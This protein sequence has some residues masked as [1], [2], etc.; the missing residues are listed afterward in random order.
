MRYLSAY[1]LI[2]RQRMLPWEREVSG[3]EREKKKTVRGLEVVDGSRELWHVR[4]GSSQVPQQL[5]NRIAL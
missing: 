1:P 5:K 4:P 2:E 3:T